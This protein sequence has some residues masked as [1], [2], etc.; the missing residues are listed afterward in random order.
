MSRKAEETSTV[1]HILYE[2]HYHNVMGDS[3]PPEYSTTRR[4]KN[5]AISG[6]T[7]H[8]SAQQ[9]PARRQ[10]KNDFIFADLEEP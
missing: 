10:R 3:N 5:D 6:S 4:R 8:A 2:H 1:I 9:A 7:A